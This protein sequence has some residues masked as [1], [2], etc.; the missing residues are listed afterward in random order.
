MPV[1][2]VEVVITV[3][4]ERKKLVATQ[5]WS[6]EG[7][8]E[9]PMRLRAYPGTRAFPLEGAHTGRRGE[10]SRKKTRWY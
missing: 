9:M 8:K 2:R 6:D 7:R 5:K 1:F 4:V 3:V 10:R